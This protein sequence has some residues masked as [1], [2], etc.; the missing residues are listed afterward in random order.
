MTTSQ[1]QTLTYLAERDSGYGV[2]DLEKVV[3]HYPNGT[4][5]ATGSLQR[6][7]GDTRE[8][9]RLA[10]EMEEEA[11]SQR[12][13]AASGKWEGQGSRFSSSILQRTEPYQPIVDF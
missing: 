4:D 11:A 7:E 12:G 5:I 2:R 10:L 6:K 13:Q 3:L 9:F 8:V 1:L